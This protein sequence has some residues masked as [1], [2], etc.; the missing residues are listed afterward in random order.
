MKPKTRNILIVIVLLIASFGIGAAWQYNQANQARQSL[1]VANTDLESVR[2]DLGLERLE[3][4]LAMAALAAQLGNHERARQFTSQFYTDL[5]S[6]AEGA[7][8]A[9]AAT[10]RSILDGRDET[11]TMLS[12][13]EP[14]A[15]LE[16][17]RML[18][19]YRQAIGRDAGGI[20]PMPPPAVPSP[21]VP[22][23]TVPA[24]TLPDTTT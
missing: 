20:A 19:Q 9:A 6:S 3:S 2:Y 13:A 10:F 11:I 15:G 8:E 17:A 18:N 24:T 16:L 22:D 1:A 21:A 23:T 12:R 7:P 4:T 5:Q 14:A